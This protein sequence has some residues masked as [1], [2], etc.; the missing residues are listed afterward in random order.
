MPKVVGQDTWTYSEIY[1]YGRRL[2]IVP[3]KRNDYDR[4]PLED[5]EDKCQKLK[6]CRFNEVERHAKSSIVS[7]LEKASLQYPAMNVRFHSTR[8]RTPGTWTCTFTVFGV[9]YT[10]D[11]RFRSK[12]EAEHAVADHAAFWALYSRPDGKFVLPTSPVYVSFFAPLI[13]I[14]Y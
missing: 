7:A 5:L 2:P 9:K 8:M 13:M 4:N 14:S 10:I 11:R 1:P 3:A 6:L 12:E